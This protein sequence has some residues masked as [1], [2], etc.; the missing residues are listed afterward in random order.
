VLDDRN[1]AAMHLPRW[2]AVLNHE[3]GMRH[4]NVIVRLPNAS[5]RGALEKVQ[6]DLCVRLAAATRPPRLFDGNHAPRMSE[7]DDGSSGDGLPRVRIGQKIDFVG[8]AATV[9]LPAV[10]GRNLGVLGSGTRDAVLV[11]EAAAATLLR[12]AGT[13]G[14]RVVLAPLVAETVASAQRLQGRFP[15]TTE[16]VRL[17][18]FRARVE[19]LAGEVTA[20]LAGD[21]RTPLVWVVYAADAADTALDR[22]GTEALR[23][24]IHFG[25]EVAVHVLGW[26]RSVPRL[27]S[28]LMMGASVDDLGAWVALDVQGSEL[29]SLLPGVLLSWSPRPG[30]GLFFDRSQHAVPEVVIVPAPEEGS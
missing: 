2:H 27:K 21:D 5:V 18:E 16:V 23:K 10:P 19:T 3:S 11:L 30:R 7:L 13:G 1:D 12:G 29:Q 8:S 9:A 26:W 28:L 4:G 20:R 17:D 22:A 24:I 25:P 6:Q 15:G 14:L